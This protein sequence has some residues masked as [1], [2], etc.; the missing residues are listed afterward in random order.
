[1]HAYQYPRSRG[2]EFHQKFEDACKRGG[3]TFYSSGTNPGFLYERVAALATGVTNDIQYIKLQEF[4]RMEN[5]SP[6]A[7]VPVGFSKTLA[8][9]ETNTIAADFASRYIRMTLHFLADK[10]GMTIDR[11]EQKVERIL[12]PKT[13]T[14][15]G[16]LTAE[17]GTIAYLV[18]SWTGYV[19]EK[20]FF[21]NELHWY[22]DSSVGPAEALHPN[23]YLVEIEGI[24]SVRVGLEVRAPYTQNLP[25]T[26]G[27]PAPYRGPAHYLACAVT[28][29]QAIPAVV[30]APAGIL[31]VDLPQFHWKP[32]MRL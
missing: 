23:Y 22:L 25:A 32:D 29:I 21:I 27:S 2:Q 17:E 15:P 1:V 10:L 30:D 26:E 16:G 11:I 7:L 19:Q 13:I 12:T 5:H 4:L 28:M 6:E 3:T 31:E 20:P 8:E 18:H 14:T 9:T 24:P